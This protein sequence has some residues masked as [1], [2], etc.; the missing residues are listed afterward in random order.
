MSPEKV[1]AFALVTNLLPVIAVIVAIGVTGWVITTWMRIK[2]G[3]PLDGKWGQALHPKHDSEAQ[4]RIRL[5][6]QENA[7][8]R[9]EV[10]SIKDR[11]VTV[12]RIVTDDGT[13]LAREIDNLQ[14]TRN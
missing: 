8:L 11:L 14:I 7:Q 1:A 10:G 12:E 4:E 6:T 9:A 3:Y 13:R 2:N 5:L